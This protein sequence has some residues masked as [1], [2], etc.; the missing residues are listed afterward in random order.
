MRD[1]LD[2]RSEFP[3]L[4]HTTYLVD[5]TARHARDP[6]RPATCGSHLN[7]V[8]NVS[9]HERGRYFRIDRGGALQER[10]VAT[11][12]IAFI[13]EVV[14]VDSTPG[15]TFAEPCGAP[16]QAEISFTR[17]PPQRV[18]SPITEIVERNRARLS[19]IEGVHGVAESR[20]PSG[21]DSI[22][23]D[24]EDDSVRERVPKEIEGY[25]V[26]VIVVPGG[27]GILPAGTAHIG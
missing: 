4:E 9:L 8:P 20:T 26:E 25:P 16:E 27:F 22:R 7:G 6:A 24:V 1:L 11:L 19:E 12:G 14:S 13:L 15:E 5:Q 10:L 21:D 17:P 23:V 3:I 2:Y 18:P